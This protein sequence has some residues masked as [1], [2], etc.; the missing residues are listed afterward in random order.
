MDIGLHVINETSYFLL[1]LLWLL[2]LNQKKK[3]EILQEVKNSLSILKDDSSTGL[4]NI[5][6]L[7]LSKWIFPFCSIQAL[8]FIV[9]NISYSRENH[10]NSKKATFDT[11]TAMQT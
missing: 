7:I 10:M 4:G 3:I 5:S 2:S 8:W 9:A 1:A 11:S 6:M